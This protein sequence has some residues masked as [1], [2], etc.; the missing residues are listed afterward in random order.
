MN[1]SFVWIFLPILLGLLLV[2]LR[3][4]RWVAFA[5]SGLCLV[6]ALSAW[7]LPVET[8]FRVGAF[9]FKLSSAF[10]VLGRRL[11]LTAADQPL[12]ALVYGSSCFW[13]AA[14]AA[15]NVARRLVPLGLIITGLLVG[16]MAVD[17]FLYAALLIEIAVL[18]TVPLLLQPGA[19]TGRGLAR[20]LIFQTL[21]MPFIIF[22]GWML[23]GIEAD[24][25][26]L[27]LVR[28]AGTLLS[29]GFSLLLAVFPFYTW[30][31]MLAEEAEPYPVGFLLWMFPTAG[32]L[33][34][35]SFIDRYT[36]LRA[37]AMDGGLLV[38]VGTLM[39]SSAGLLAAFQK[40]LGRIMGYAAIVEIGFSLVTIGAGNAP[41]VTLF[42]L[43]F[44]PRILSLG[45]WSFS[46][47]ALKEQRPSLLLADCRGQGRS[48]PLASA[49]LVLS[50]FALAG[51]PMLASF[52]IRQAIWEGLATSSP[53]AAAWLLAGVF[54]LAVAAVRTLAA[55]TSAPE[56]AAWT[57]REN[58]PQRIYIGL[59]LLGLLGLGMF[60]QWT[61]PL[62][63]RLPSIFEHL[64]R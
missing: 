64:G 29:L 5:A 11:V 6:L 17:P 13:F 60:P 26:A 23:A 7:L 59:G 53:G 50:N 3:N 16:A 43:L 25:G 31:P 24:P 36:W 51:L 54:G 4:E 40:H 27:A 12:L 58:W 37:A 62:L 10:D 18:M 35:A 44:I 8:V 32:L 2:F 20:F 28:Q 45:L 46:L 63:E 38:T 33:F 41:G 15:L 57:S 1:A 55:L 30:I 49:G 34:A 39:I 48:L 14:S 47:A 52:P 42:F 19:R 21:A 22:S 56:G 61:A 9:S